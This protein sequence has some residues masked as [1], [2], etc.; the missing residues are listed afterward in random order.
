MGTEQGRW[1]SKTIESEKH[2]QG[3]R[4]KSQTGNPGLGII[5]TLP[6]CV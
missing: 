6:S 1:Q 2:S 5:K 4:T 3:Q